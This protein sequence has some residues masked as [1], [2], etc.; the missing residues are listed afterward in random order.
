[1]DIVF[2]RSLIHRTGQA[3]LM[4]IWS[5]IV[6]R[7]RSHFWQSHRKYPDIMD[8]YREHRDIVNTFRKG[9]LEQSVKVLTESMS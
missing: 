7:L 2:H 3:D 9:D 4:A 8:V 6:A 1:V 5:S